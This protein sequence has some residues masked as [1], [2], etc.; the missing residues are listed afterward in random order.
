MTVPEGPRAES[1]TCPTMFW[2][3][4]TNHLFPDCEI[5]F[6]VNSNSLR[7]NGPRCGSSKTLCLSTTAGD[8]EESSNDGSFQG[9]LLRASIISPHCRSEPT[10]SPAPV[11]HDPSVVMDSVELSV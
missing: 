1:R 3:K 7:M 2:P 8:H 4:S 10:I 9:S 5:C 6:G 11:F